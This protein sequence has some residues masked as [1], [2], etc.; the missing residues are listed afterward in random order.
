M[1]AEV[2]L[3]LAQYRAERRRVGA[4]VTDVAREPEAPEPEALER[5]ERPERV[6]LR[7][8]AVGLEDAAVGYLEA[9]EGR[10]MPRARMLQLRRNS[11]T[12]VDACSGNLK[13]LRIGLMSS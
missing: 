3:E 8:V 2:Q 6:A 10:G 4:E 12:Y 11:V 9:P 13:T 5:R 7:S 1:R